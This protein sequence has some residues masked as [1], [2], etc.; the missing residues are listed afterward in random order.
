MKIMYFLLLG[1]CVEYQG[2]LIEQSSELHPGWLTIDWLDQRHFVS[3]SQI[4][5]SAPLASYV[6]LKISIFPS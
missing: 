5:F 6:Y 1:Q 4:I 3:L 2:T